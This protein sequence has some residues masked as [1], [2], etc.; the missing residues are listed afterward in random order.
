MTVFKIVVCRLFSLE[1]FKICG[2]GKGLMQDMGPSRTPL[3]YGSTKSTLSNKQL[4]HA[5]DT[6]SVCFFKCSKFN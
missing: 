4:N 2:L 6:H 1:E 5:S 3:N